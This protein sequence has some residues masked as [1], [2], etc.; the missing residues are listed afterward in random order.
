MRLNE[1]R[2]MAVLAELSDEH[3]VVPAEMG[4][5]VVA[6]MAGTHWLCGA[7]GCGLETPLTAEGVRYIIDYVAS[8]GGRPRI[9][10]TDASGKDAF[11]LVAEAGLVLD[12]AERVLKRDLL[13]PIEAPPVPGLTIEKLDPYKKDQVERHARHTVDGFMPPGTPATDPELQAAIRS[14]TH[15]RSRGFLAT[16]D[17]DLAGTCG[18]EVVA[19]D[20]GPGKVPI[21]VASLWGAVVGEPYRRLGIQQALIAHRLVQGKQEG[22]SI[23]VIECEPGIPTERN[24]GRL[25]FVPAYTRLAFKAPTSREQAEGSP[26]SI[27]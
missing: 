11:K 8:R 25:G 7:I 4:G 6:F 14:L 21:R 13:T 24:A 27:G 5:G 22:C 20:Q 2:Q 18:M 1:R 9:D 19:I 16:L 15:Q 26:E 23:A 10:L 3:E 12:H 17:S